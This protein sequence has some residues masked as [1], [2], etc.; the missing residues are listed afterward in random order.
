M[1]RVDLSEVDGIAILAPDSQLSKS[2]F[3]SAAQVIDPY[4]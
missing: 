4:I 2:D 1:L 3:I